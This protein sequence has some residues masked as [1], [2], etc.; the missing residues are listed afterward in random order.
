MPKLRRTHLLEELKGAARPLVACQTGRG[1]FELLYYADE[2][3]AIRLNNRIL[4]VWEHDQQEDCMQ[5]FGQMI[6]LGKTG[7]VLVVRVPVGS[8]TEQRCQEPFLN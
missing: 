8:L 5:A 3:W 4:G 1:K 7:K 2:S 6:G